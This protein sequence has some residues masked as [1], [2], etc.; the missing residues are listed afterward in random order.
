MLSACKVAQLLAASR[1]VELVPA[2][3]QAGEQLL[4]WGK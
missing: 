4:P 3:E 2:V 1:L